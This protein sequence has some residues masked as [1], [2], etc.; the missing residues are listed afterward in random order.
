LP[1]RKKRVPQKRRDSGP[2][3]VSS[4]PSLPNRDSPTEFSHSLSYRHNDAGELAR[5]PF[6]VIRDVLAHELGHVFQLQHEP[7]RPFN[8]MYGGCPTIPFIV[9]CLFFDIANLSSVDALN[10]VQIKNARANALQL[11]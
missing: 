3:V 9:P 1:T 4:C 10:D 6:H 11:Q 5:V 7:F 2:Q 8:L